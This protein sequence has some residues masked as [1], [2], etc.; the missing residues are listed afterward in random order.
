[1]F[2]PTTDN[3]RIPSRHLG[4]KL[5]EFL[6]KLTYLIYQEIFFFSI[7]L[8]AALTEDKR[9]II[10]MVNPSNLNGILSRRWFLFHF[11]NTILRSIVLRYSW[12]KFVLFLS[13][14]VVWLFLLCV[15]LIP[16]IK[17]AHVDFLY[18][19]LWTWFS[20]PMKYLPNDFNNRENQ[21]KLEEEM[22]LQE[23]NKK[24]EAESHRFSSFTG[25]V[26]RFNIFNR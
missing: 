6:G 25:G 1:M 18:F 15:T 5:K 23:E 20:L 9:F 16:L 3:L 10:W 4:K 13:N 7:I 24:K 12:P 19:F 8:Y 17:I 2:S 21:R 14:N 11:V 26:S 22:R